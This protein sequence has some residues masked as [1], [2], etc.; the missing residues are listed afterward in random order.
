MN[1]YKEEAKSKFEQRGLFKSLEKLQDNF[2]KTG[3]TIKLIKKYNAIDE[4]ATKIMLKAENNCVSNFC[5]STPWSTTLI[6]ASRTV[7]YWNLR[8]TKY[9][10]K[11]V[12]NKT[13]QKAQEESEVIDLTTPKKEAITYRITAKTALKTVITEADKVREEKLKKRA[14]KAAIEGITKVTLAYEVLIG[15]KKIRAT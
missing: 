6:K 1:K 13:L 14:N 10:N 7:R 15:H 8:I 2:S 4:E 5:F 3:P 11:Q 9:N 12:S